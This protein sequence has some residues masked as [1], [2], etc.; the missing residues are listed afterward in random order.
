MSAYRKGVGAE[1]DF[2]EYMEKNHG[3]R[4]LRTAGSHTPIDV[5]A[6]NGEKVYAVQVKY[7]VWKRKVDVELLRQWAK[8]FNAIPCIASR[9][10]YGSWEIQ[11][12]V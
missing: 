11:M 12:D 8:M 4:C 9:R 1:R 10:R 6:G 2:M 5:L 7:G 3:C